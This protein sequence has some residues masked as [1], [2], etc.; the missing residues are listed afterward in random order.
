MEHS[1]SFWGFASYIGDHG[2]HLHSQ[3]R[4]NMMSACHV[5]YICKHCTRHLHG[6]TTL[7]Q[8]GGA[9]WKTGCFR[10][11]PRYADMQ[12]A[13]TPVQQHALVHVTSSLLNQH[14]SVSAANYTYL[15]AGRWVQW[16]MANGFKSP[17]GV[18]AI[19]GL[20]GLP[21]W[22]WACR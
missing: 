8:G 16:T 11:A 9:A 7:S 10:Q 18:L 17:L 1:C 15:S 13:K 3:G 19:A 20:M 6:V 12:K 5:K 22:L 4:S 21:L 2:L 14:I